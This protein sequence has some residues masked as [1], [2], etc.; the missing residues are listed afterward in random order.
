MVKLCVILYF[1]IGLYFAYI[2]A[3]GLEDYRKRKI[4]FYFLK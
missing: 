4:L 2:A 3:Y 1:V